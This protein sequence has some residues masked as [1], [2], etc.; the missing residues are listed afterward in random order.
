MLELLHAR[1]ASRYM[2]E[3]F[4]IRFASCLREL[5]QLIRRWAPATIRIGIVPRYG[6]L[7]SSN[8][9]FFK[10]NVVTFIPAR[11]TSFVVRHPFTPLPSYVCK[12]KRKNC[13]PR[14]PDT[15][16]FEE[17]ATLRSVA[18]S[19]KPNRIC[20]GVNRHQCLPSMKLRM[21]GGR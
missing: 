4:W 6:A 15:E 19:A 7:K 2:I 5:S 1:P 11:L 13:P 14:L 17:C 21:V 3:K 12:Q 8:Q 9:L 16:I 20:S 18:S 10:I